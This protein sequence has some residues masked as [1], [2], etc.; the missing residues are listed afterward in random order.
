MAEDRRKV[1][2][3]FAGAVA[4]LHHQKPRRAGGDTRPEQAVDQAQTQLGPGH[5][6]GGGNQVT[7]IDN[8]RIGLEFDGR[9][10]FGEGFRGGPVSGG[11][12]AVEQTA[13]SEQN[14]P[15]AHPAQ[16]RA[17]GMLLAQPADQTLRRLAFGETGNRRRNQ[18][19]HHC[20]IRAGMA[21]IAA[22]RRLVAHNLPMADAQ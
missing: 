17:V 12:A 10:T 22:L 15:Y 8:G 3:A 6:P 18:H 20:A 13:F 9:V 5:Q 1:T 21:V 19:G 4:V 7:V 2:A 14:R 16:R 11:A